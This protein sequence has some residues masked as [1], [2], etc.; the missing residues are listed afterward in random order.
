L[1]LLL[2]PYFTL[3]AVYNELKDLISLENA[4]DIFLL[5]RSKKIDI[6]LLCDVRI[7]LVKAH[8]SKLFR[9]TDQTITVLEEDL[10]ATK[11]IKEA[12]KSEA[13]DS[14]WVTNESDDFLILDGANQEIFLRPLNC[15]PIG[16][17]LSTNFEY[18]QSLWL[19]GF[20]PPIAGENLFAV[21]YCGEIYLV[22]KSMASNPYGVKVVNSGTEHRGVSYRL[23]KSLVSSL[24]LKNKF[25]V[26][27]AEMSS[28]ISSHQNLNDMT[29]FDEHTPRWGDLF[30]FP[31]QRHSSIF[32]CY[33]IAT[34]SF[35]ER[36]KKLPGCSEL[37]EEMKAIYGFDEHKK[38]IINVS[39]TTIDWPAFRRYFDLRTKNT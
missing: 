20:D 10:V 37:W 2:K 8:T 9:I 17:P 30:K 33:K 14:I 11:P 34:N 4:E 19:K 6:Q 12:L 16:P 29:E 38:G 13:L 32:E 5:A 7:T 21:E 18:K 36:N 26:S 27:Q 15:I 23:D 25:V 3:E 35:I 28:F 24:I 39:F 22:C 31:P 1:S